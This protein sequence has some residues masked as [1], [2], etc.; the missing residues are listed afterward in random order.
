[1]GTVPD[2]F[3]HPTEGPTAIHVMYRRL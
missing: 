1:V 3:R 2:A